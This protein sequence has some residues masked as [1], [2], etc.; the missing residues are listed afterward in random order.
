[1]E[2]SL[3]IAV[4]NAGEKPLF[5]VYISTQRWDT[6][7]RVSISL[8][9]GETVEAGWLELPS[10]LQ[11]GDIVEIYAEGFDAPFKAELP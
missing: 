1:M 4:T 11:R 6:K 9:P 5:D 2:D 8:R 10:G 7:H 3:V